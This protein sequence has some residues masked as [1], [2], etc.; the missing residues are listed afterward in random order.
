MA[1][2]TRFD[3]TKR[4]EVTFKDKFGAFKKGD[5][6]TVG[7]ALAADWYAK[8]KVA[9]S[10]ELESYI[11]EHELQDMFGMKENKAE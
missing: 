10:K 9:L 7:L 8:G 5:K 3:S 2:I 6:S 4:F 1:K 11:A